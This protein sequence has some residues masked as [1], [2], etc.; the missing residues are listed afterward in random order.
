MGKDLLKVGQTF[1]VANRM[2]PR[3]A[4]TPFTIQLK[5]CLR[6]PAPQMS[7]I[8]RWLP[9]R[10][11]AHR[12]H[13]EWFAGRIAGRTVFKVAERDGYTAIDYPIRRESRGLKSGRD[14]AL[15]AGPSGKFVNI[16]ERPE[17]MPQMIDLTKTNLVDAAAVSALAVD[18]G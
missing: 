10:L 11:L 17:T 2:K 1:N 9:A 18:E 15:I 3:S 14:G 12:I 7:E 6:V 16:G 5:F 4:A 13:K 8:E